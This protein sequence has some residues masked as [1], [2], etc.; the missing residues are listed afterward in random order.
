MIVKSFFV[1]KKEVAN[2]GV[3][4][5]ERI[6]EF[7]RDLN[8]FLLVR[9]EKTGVGEGF[10][11]PRRRVPA[12][13]QRSKDQRGG[14]TV[15]GVKCEGVLILSLLAWRLQPVQQH[16]LKEDVV[17]ENAEDGP[18]RHA[19]LDAGDALLDDGGDECLL[20]F[21]DLVVFVVS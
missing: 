4:V 1:G 17:K 20:M 21:L 10:V 19:G 15:A 18:T 7:S 3:V 5:L 8:N 11:F 12:S 6:E 2:E 13:G 9:F 14:A 16:S